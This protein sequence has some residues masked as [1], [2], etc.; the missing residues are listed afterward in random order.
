LAG[1]A[2][3]QMRAQLLQWREAYR[4]FS[5]APVRVPYSWDMFA[6]RLERCTIRWDP[7]LEIDGKPV[8]TWHDR[9][10]PI[11]FDTVYNRARD[12]YGAARTGC[13]FRSE[14]KT[15]TTVVCVHGNGKIDEHSIECP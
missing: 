9:A 13:A 15:V 12:Y 4:P 11:E 3:V 7:P 10:F 6:I 14:P 8:S 2:A 1:I 5:H